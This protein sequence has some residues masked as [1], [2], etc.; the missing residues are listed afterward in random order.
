M[1]LTYIDESGTHQGSKVLVLAAYIGTSDE[2]KFAEERFRRANKYSGTTF[3]AVDCAQGGNEFRGIDKDKRN[4]ITKKMVRIVNDHDLFGV[5]YGGYI[6]DYDAVWPRDR[7]H[8]ETWLSKLF[9]LL[10][11]GLIIDLCNYTRKYH[12]GERVSVTMEQSQ[13]WYPIAA[14]RFQQMKQ[15]TDWADHVLL[16]SIAACSKEQAPQLHAPDLLAYEGYLMK[17]RERFPTTHRPRRSLL[18]LLTKRKDGRIW[19]KQAF[20]T[21]KAMMEKGEVKYVTGLT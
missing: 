19:N 3:H 13:H 4:R 5:I 16:D 11:G 6:E 21:L 17:L 15:E 14:K 1:V 12:P 8:W 2:W 7:R 20:E 9:I 10:F 18:S